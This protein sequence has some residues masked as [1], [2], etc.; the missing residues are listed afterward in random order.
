[1]PAGLVPVGLGETIVT[2]RSAPAARSFRS[3]GGFIP[4]RMR[5]WRRA[6]AAMLRRRRRGLAVTRRAAVFPRQSDADQLL[7]VAQV[8]QFF[9]PR[10]QRNCDAISASARRAAD[11]MDV[12]F[13]YV[14][15]I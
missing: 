11:A 10:N 4:C 15:K 1:M 3:R 2:S 14:G 8:S 7:N 6:C 9:S 5:A 13:G 12:G